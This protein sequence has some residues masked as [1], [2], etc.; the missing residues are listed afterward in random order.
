MQSW[1]SSIVIVAVA[2]AAAMSAS[3]LRLPSPPPLVFSSSSSSTSSSTRWSTPPPHHDHD[4]D[5]DHHQHQH[6]T[7]HVAL[8]QQLP[9][10]HLEKVVQLAAVRNAPTMGAVAAGL[11]RWRHALLQGHLPEEE[12]GGDDVWPGG[13]LFTELSATFA[14]LLLPQLVVR[15]PELVTPV[16]TDCAQRVASPLRGDHARPPSFAQCCRVIHHKLSSAPQ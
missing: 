5:H 8:L 13:A 10:L 9:A 2:A 6:H 16:L 15:H 14:Q 1:A 4:H 7:R 11:D 3:A 12:D